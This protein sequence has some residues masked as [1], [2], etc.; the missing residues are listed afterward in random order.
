MVAILFLTGLCIL[1]LFGSLVL[2][3]LLLEAARSGSW[4]FVALT[5]VMI[6]AVVLLVVGSEMDRR[7]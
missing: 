5:I 7:G 2:G 1:S 3:L 6:A 4:G